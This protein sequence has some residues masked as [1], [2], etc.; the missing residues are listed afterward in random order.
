M[1]LDMTEKE[2]SKNRL[3][4][5]AKWFYE[6]RKDVLMLDDGQGNKYSVSLDSWNKMHDEFKEKYGEEIY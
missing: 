4:T 3:L 5:L 1:E 6:T 2:K